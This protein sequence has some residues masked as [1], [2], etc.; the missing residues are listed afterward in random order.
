MREDDRVSDSVD[1]PVGLGVLVIERVRTW[2]RDGVSLGLGICDCED[3]EVADG[4]FDGDRD[5]LALPDWERVGDD[6]RVCERVRE[7]DRVEERVI[8][9]VGVG[10]RIPLRV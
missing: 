10:E 5:T 8:D 9:C 2:L 7:V 6:E 1:A 4:E 3:D